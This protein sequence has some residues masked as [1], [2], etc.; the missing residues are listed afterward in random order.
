MVGLDRGPQPE[1]A[2][3]FL[4]TLKRKEREG[5]EIKFKKVKG[6]SGVEGN[7]EADRR[8]KEGL[9]WERTYLN[10]IDLIGYR[11]E[12]DLRYE[13]KIIKSNYRREL[14]KI[15]ENRV[16]IAAKEDKNLIWRRMNN[17][18]G[19]DK[20][21][22]EIIRD[23]RIH[24]SIVGTIVKARTDMLPH[25]INMVKRK[26]ENIPNTKCPFCDKEEGTEHIIIEC[27][28]YREIREKTRTKVYKLMR[29]KIGGMGTEEGLRK[30][31][32]VWFS[33]DELEPEKA[34]PYVDLLNYDK[35][36][37]ALGFIPTKIRE[38]IREKFRKKKRK[39]EVGKKE[40]KERAEKIGMILK[41]I[42]YIIMKGTKQ[43]WKE[44]NRK[45]KERANKIAKERRREKGF[46][47][48]VEKRKEQGEIREQTQSI[49]ITKVWGKE[50]KPIKKT[51]RGREEEPQEQEGEERREEIEGESEG[52]KEEGSIS[53][54]EFKKLVAEEE[55]KKRKREK[56]KERRVTKRRETRKAVTGNKKTKIKTKPKTQKDTNKD[57]ITK[58]KQK[59]RGTKR[60]YKE[61]E[62][63]LER[64]KRLKKNGD[65]EEQRRSSRL[66]GKR[67]TLGE[68]IPREE[69]TQKI[70]EKKR[71]KRKREEGGSEGRER[72]E[73]VQKRKRMEEEILKEDKIRQEIRH[74]KRGRKIIT[75]ERMKEEEGK[76]EKTDRRRGENKKIR[77]K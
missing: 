74:S 13:E 28:E 72:G 16:E 20:I 1:I 59:E 36:A 48:I 37:G 22:N 52:E 34:S 46:D 61:K 39:G 41:K 30:L 19:A 35:L 56:N 3:L 44:R 63:K 60:R 58:E 31:I 17:I 75:E 15:N 21:G 6:H 26:Y 45:W 49:K 12:I 7:E 2:R 64:K 67:I 70:E 27:E 69:R 77:K 40:N 18:E 68:N 32:P 47:T 14:K 5:A 50:I 4:E 42:N 38:V 76:G 65:N 10:K 55:K 62:G 71:E 66:A 11:N 51:T 53:T 29:E 25:A 73:E 54:E 43:I 23:R 24:K 57:D 8:A 33:R 9:E